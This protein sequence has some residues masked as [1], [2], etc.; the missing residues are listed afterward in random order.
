MSLEKAKLQELNASNN[1]TVGDE[2]AVQ[3]NPASLRVQISNTTERG[4]S[5]GRQRRQYLGQSS[6]KLTVQ[7]VYDTAD[8][9]PSGDNQPRSVRERTRSV[10]QFATPVPSGSRQTIKKLRFSWG[11]FV[12]EGIMDTLTIDVD[13]FAENGVP[14][15]AKLDIGITEQRRDYEIRPTQD[16][17]PP[18]PEQ[19]ASNGPG[20]SGTG[21][22][23]GGGGGGGG[24]GSGGGGATDRTGTA[25]AGESAADFAARNGVDPAAWRSIA[26]Q[27]ANPLALTAGQSINFA[28]GA[29]VAVGMGA[30]VG[31]G[32]N[33]GVGL[34]ASLGA[35]AR[36]GT[37]ALAAGFAVAAAGGV[38][39][40]IATVQM[41]T[42]TAAAQ[43]TRS[44]F[45]SAAPAAPALPPA[46]KT[47]IAAAGSS[48]ASEV[49]AAAKPARPD[50]PRTPLARSAASGGGASS[51]GGSSGAPAPAPA[52]PRVDGRA[53]SFGAG[54]PLRPPFHPPRDRVSGLGGHV[55]LKP[56]VL[57]EP[58]PVTED[59]TVPP[60]VALPA[61]EPSRAAADRA[62]Q[63]RGGANRCG[64]SCGGR[65]SGGCGCGPRGSCSCNGGTRR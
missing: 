9:S 43:E 29:S 11:D 56:Q 45:P 31:V 44:S 18:P 63:Q 4:R 6:S 14:L 32:A 40:A 22:D 23:G 19:G 1:Q 25:Q 27:V 8:E 3:F 10:E 37:A 58:V 64:C 62:Q 54:V 33:V 17:S 35:S 7:L 55:S 59:P 65:S 34:S 60:W 30:T 41:A 48:G 46:V 50:Q 53:V 13:L 39:A 2:I 12:F 38:D 42:A 49:G 20:T 26:N 16:T 28:T 51:G 24:G 61:V 21:D 47:A 52:P 36:G 5:R 57:D 15:R